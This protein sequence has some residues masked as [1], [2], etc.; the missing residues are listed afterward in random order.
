MR[1]TLVVGA[2]LL[3]TVALAACNRD[4]TAQAPAAT[5]TAADEPAPGSA[6][7]VVSAVQDAAAGLV[8]VISAEMTTTV[9]G[10]VKA[11]AVSDMYEIESSRLA[12]ERTK[13]AEVKS[14]AQEMIDA[15]TKTSNELKSILATQK[16]EVALPAELDGRR[17]EM[18]ENL[19]GA[20]DADFDGRYLNQQTNAHQEA[21]ILFRGYAESGDN[22]QLKQFAGTHL[23]HIEHHLEMV[24]ALDKSG[25]DNNAV[26]GP[27]EPARQ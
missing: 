22:P 12:L 27:L 26:G 25:A 4:E 18:M 8:G 16:I 19:K 7:E 2:L 11:A 23:P 1:R 14:F 10:Y 13:S 3:S 9:Q 20:S 5:E 24:K 6:N 17:T 21:V 15:H